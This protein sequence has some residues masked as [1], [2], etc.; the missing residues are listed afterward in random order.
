[1]HMASAAKISG[2]EPVRRGHARDFAVRVRSF[3]FNLICQDL[4]LTQTR[5]SSIEQAT[6]LGFC[7]ELLEQ[8]C[9]MIWKEATHKK[10][11][12]DGVFLF[13]YYFILPHCVRFFASSG[14]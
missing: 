6:I 12:N 8:S 3:N 9:E 14:P 2:S 11:N 10:Q 5:A 13:G 4:Q 7:R 1:M